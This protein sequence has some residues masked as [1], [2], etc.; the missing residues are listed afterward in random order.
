MMVTIALIFLFLGL[1]RI[2]GELVN[3]MELAYAIV[4]GLFLLLGAL[5]WSRRINKRTEEN[6]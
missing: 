4:G 1:F 5:L 2:L 3:D 6:P